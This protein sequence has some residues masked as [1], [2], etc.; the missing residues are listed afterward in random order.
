MQVLG[1]VVIREALQII[2]GAKAPW[3]TVMQS[4]TN[5]IQLIRIVSIWTI[6]YREQVAVGRKRH[7][8]GVARATGQNQSLRSQGFLI[9]WQNLF[10]GAGG[11]A[12]DPGSEGHVAGIWE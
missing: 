12:Q 7:I 4:L 2:V 11:D 8:V 6:V 10:S 9:I 5:P 1:W 3:K